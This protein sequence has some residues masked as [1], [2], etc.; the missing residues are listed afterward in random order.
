MIRR[1]LFAALSLIVVSIST[2][3]LAQTERY[4]IETPH[5]QILFNVN[6]LGF[7]HSYG[8]FY[9]YEGTIDFNEENP[10]ESSVSVTIH[11]AS[12]DMG[13]E[14][15]ND[16]M[17]NEDF[18]DVEN[19]PAMTFEST[20]IEVT[21]ENT[22]NITGELTLLGISKA[23]T[24]ETVLNKAGDHPM[25]GKKGIGFSAKATINRS[26]FGME[27]GLPAVGDEVD[28][29]IEVEAYKEPAPNE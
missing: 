19:Y 17:K 7:S 9:D 29:I 3:A 21:G 18:F 5:T 16:H 2:D 8:K 10:S 20:D 28:I 1:M 26:D 4:V 12:I 23:V 27:Y 24:L 14:K 6:H 22:A 11:T 13:T 25:S 15:W